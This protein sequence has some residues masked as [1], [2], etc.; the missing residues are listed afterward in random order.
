MRKQPMSAREKKAKRRAP[1]INASAKLRARS[2][3][4]WSQLL[5]IVF[6]EF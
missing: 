1:S 2:L 3:I 4:S 5:V 6:P